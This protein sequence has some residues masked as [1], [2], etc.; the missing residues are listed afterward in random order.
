MSKKTKTK[1]ETPVKISTYQKLAMR[2]CMPSC[3]NVDYDFLGLCSEIHEL[4]AKIAGYYAKEIRGDSNL[5]EK[6]KGIAEEV[7]DCFWFVALG[8]EIYSLSFSKNL[9][10]KPK[11]L[12]LS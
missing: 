2:T 10:S 8:C 5:E 7:G 4:K 9:F 12:T 6:I 3:R 11:I 1:K